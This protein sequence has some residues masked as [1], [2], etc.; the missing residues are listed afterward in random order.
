MAS[1]ATSCFPCFVSSPHIETEIAPQGS[2]SPNCDQLEQQ[3][4]LREHASNT[5]YLGLCRGSRHGTDYDLC[6]LGCHGCTFGNTGNEHP[7]KFSWHEFWHVKQG[8]VKSYE[9][10]LL[11]LS[12]TVLFLRNF[13]AF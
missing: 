8:L 4:H 2:L 3:L 5:I 13:S 12:L 11:S 10:S 9:P 6:S 7:P 1:L